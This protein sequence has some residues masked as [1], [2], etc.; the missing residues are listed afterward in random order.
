M[1]TFILKQQVQKSQASAAG[2]EQYDG[3][4]VLDT[5]NKQ[6][7]VFAQLTETITGVTN[8]QHGLNSGFSTLTLIMLQGQQGQ[9]S[10]GGGGGGGGHN[11]Q[12]P[13]SLTL[14]GAV[15]FDGHPP[16]PPTAGQPR[17]IMQMTGSVAA[18]SQPFA[19]LIAHTFVLDRTSPTMWKLTIH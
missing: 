15:T 8:G 5:N 14:E 9:H 4:D 11:A 3:G 2:V 13:E 16:T 19:N 18:A 12:A 6:V 1:P 10:G 7:A 17:D